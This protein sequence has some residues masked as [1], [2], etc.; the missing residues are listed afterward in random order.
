MRLLS[1]QRLRSVNT[2]ISSHLQRPSASLFNWIKPVT[3]PE[4]H[5]LVSGMDQSQL[6]D[7]T[8]QQGVQFQFHLFFFFFLRLICCY[9]WLHSTGVK[10]I[11]YT[12]FPRCP[13]CQMSC[14]RCVAGGLISFPTSPWW[15]RKTSRGKCQVRGRASATRGKQPVCPGF[16]V[17]ACQTSC[18]SWRSSLEGFLVSGIRTLDRKKE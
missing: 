2:G 18:R 4:L 11:I 16:L 17:T 14:V 7:Q 15:S 13:E 9:V 8:H 10:H 3:S 12:R 6:L 1:W 5:M